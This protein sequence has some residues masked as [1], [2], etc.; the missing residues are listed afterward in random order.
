MDCIKLKSNLEKKGYKV[1]L[2][3]NES[4]T[5]EYLAGSIRGM[6]IG[7]GGSQTLTSLNLQHILTKNN[8][9][10]VPDFPPEGETFDSMAVK[11]MNTDVYLLSANAISENGEIVNID[12]VGNRLA[13]SL[14]GHKKV[15]YIVSENKIGGTLEQAVQRARNVAAPKNALGMYRRTPC[16]MATMKR[17][18]QKYREQYSGQNPEDDQMQWQKFIEGLTEEELNTHCYDCKS[19][20]RLCGSLLIHWKK[21]DSAE[22]EVVIMKSNKGF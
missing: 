22:A 4:E 1:S 15:F 2:F 10:F 7:F 20:D 6:S 19:P 3:D 5:I 12:L 21:P 8:R 18:A 17:L 9:V 11:A 14:F 16:A 13:G